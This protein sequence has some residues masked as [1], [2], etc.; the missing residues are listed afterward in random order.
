MMMN[1]LNDNE[2][3]KQNTNNILLNIYNYNNIEHKENKVNLNLKYRMSYLM[4]RSV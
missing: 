1:N 4:D 2:K 3:C